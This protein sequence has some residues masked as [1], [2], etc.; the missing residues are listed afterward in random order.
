M[1]R[2]SKTKSLLL[3]F[4]LAT[5]TITA[6]SAVSQGNPSPDEQALLELANQSR[7]QYHLPP[8]R[9]DNALAAAARNHL[10]WVLRN[11]SNLQHQYPGEP[12]LVARGGNA[13]ARFGTISENIAGHGQTPTDLHNIW[14]TTPT[15][16]ANLLDPKLNVVGIAVAENQGLL[17]AVQDFGREVPSLTPEAVER[18]VQKLLQAQ[19][20]SPAPSNEDARKTCTMAQGQAGFPKLVIQWDGSDISHLPDAVLQN[21]DKTKYKTAAVGAC[22]GRQPNQQFTTYHIAL[23]L[24]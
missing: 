18:Q 13:G 16:R 8:L 24:Y 7:A 12:D 6:S 20:F 23:L 14:M 11:P 19:G 9:W 4:V 21:L 1:H 22:P 5:M 15:H 3:L 10:R 17:F 2:K